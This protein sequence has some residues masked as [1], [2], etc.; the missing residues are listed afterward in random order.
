MV[1]ERLDPAH[2]VGVGAVVPGSRQGSRL[3][4]PSAVHHFPGSLL[5]NFGDKILPSLCVCH[6]DNEITG[7]ESRASSLR[8]SIFCPTSFAIKF[9]PSSNGPRT[10]FASAGYSSSAWPEA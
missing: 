4:L 6:P 10:S 1:N 9:P 8:A 2:R 7:Q 5:A 3:E